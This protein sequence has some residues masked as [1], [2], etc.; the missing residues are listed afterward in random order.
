MTRL[1]GLIKNLGYVCK[2]NKVDFLEFCSQKCKMH[3][4]PFV[5]TTIYSNTNLNENNLLTLLKLNVNVLHV[6]RVEPNDS[7]ARWLDRDY[8]HI[9]ITSPAWY[10]K[11][12]LSIKLA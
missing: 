3:G 9:T 1:P 8:R 7:N 2:K 6:L 12:V 11:L 4:F 10:N 5:E